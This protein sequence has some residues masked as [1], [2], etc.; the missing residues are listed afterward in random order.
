MSEDRTD[1]TN[2][3][4]SFEERV[5]ARFDA[6]D[7]RIENLEMR[8]YDTKPMWEQALAAISETNVQMRVGF[9]TIS[10]R[11]ETMDERLISLGTRFDSLETRFESL[12]TRFDSLETRFD[13]LETRF[14]SLETRFESLET[15][16]DSLGTRFDS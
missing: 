11:L 13:S 16:F 8:H 5:F 14:D 6:M 15:R 4:R 3:S 12:E 1:E 10:A 7:N 9:E 2:G